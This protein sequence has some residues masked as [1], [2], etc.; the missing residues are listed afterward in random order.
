M[1]PNFFFFL[2]FLALLSSCKNER[3]TDRELTKLSQEEVYDMIVNRQNL[4]AEHAVYKNEEGNIISFD[5]VKKLPGKL[6]SDYY[7][8][9]RNEIVEIVMRKATSSDKTFEKELRSGGERPVLSVEIDCEQVPQ[10]LQAVH[11]SDQE[12]RKTGDLD[13]EVDFK[14][15]TTVINL[16]EQCGMPT[17]KDVNQ[18]Q[19]SAIWL[20]F[21]HADNKYRKRY[22]P[23]LRV[24]AANGDLKKTQIAM[25]QDRILMSEGKPQIY[26][27][28]VT[29]ANGSDAWELYDLRNP[30]TVDKRRARL[31]WEPL[32]DYLANWDIEFTTEQI[33]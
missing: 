14:N 10:I 18:E 7:V 2:S 32:K 33:Q 22:F 11:D 1:K 21:Q 29:K 13:S 19:M 12:M 20:V 5:S 16:I 27:T 8:N 24:A 15:L 3:E 4:N 6:T 17:L 28:Q 30:E 9:E 26:G 23:Q 25:M 31:G